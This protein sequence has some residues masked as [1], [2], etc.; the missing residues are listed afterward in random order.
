MEVDERPVVAAFDFDKTLTSRDCVL[1]FLGRNLSWSSVVRLVSMVPVLA[2]S[3]VR[4]DRDRVKMLVSHGVFKGRSKELVDRSGESYA[5]RILEKWLRHDAREQLRWHQRQGHRCVIVSASYLSY[6]A[7]I[8]RELGFDE[9]LSTELEF[10]TTGRATGNLLRGNCRGEEKAHRLRA[11]IETLGTEG[12]VLY[13]YGD[14]S[15]D[16]EML[17]MADHPRR[18]TRK[19]FVP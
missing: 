13:A 17:S 2:A 8:A 1:E 19:R 12:V 11:W 14:S 16:H 3:A 4:R 6:L 7:P 15:G 9:V 10:D 5:M 18:V